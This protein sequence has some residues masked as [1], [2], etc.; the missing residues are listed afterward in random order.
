MSAEAL[1]T[2][3]RVAIITGA[4][5]GVGQATAILFAEKGWRCA[6]LGRTKSKLAS[7]AADFPESS[8]APLLIECDLGRA[9]EM[10]V[11]IQR[12]LEH[13]GRI[14]LRYFLVPP[15]ANCCL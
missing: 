14:D 4:G 15:F 13:F 1:D 11:V 5:S 12:T 2:V 10:P 7:T 6:L 9:D 8:P 3:E